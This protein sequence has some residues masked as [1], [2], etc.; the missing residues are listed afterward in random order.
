MLLKIFFIFILASLPLFAQL[1]HLDISPKKVDIDK[2]RIDIL[3]SVILDYDRID[4]QKFFGISALA[5]DKNSSILYML[6]DRSRLFAFKLTLK[7]KKIDT[8][9]PL[10]GVRLKDRYGH[11]F[12]IKKSDSEGMTL[13]EEDGKKSLLISFENH[14]RIMEFD[15]RGKEIEKKEKSLKDVRRNLRLKK[16]PK[17]LQTKRV[18][19]SS[20]SMLESVTVSKK[21]VVVVDTAHLVTHLALQNPLAAVSKQF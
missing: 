19:K 3:D 21:L 13:V 16:L 15:L 18:Y 20:N 1:M 9:R 6:S 12:F 11:K 8:L 7:D 5:Y 14:V 17:I 4:S 10:Y 2:V